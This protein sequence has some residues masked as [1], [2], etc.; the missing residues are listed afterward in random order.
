MQNAKLI[1]IVHLE[2]T[3]LV[4][5]ERLICRKNKFMFTY[6]STYIYVLSYQI[7]CNK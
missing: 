2:E 1:L 5:F 7:L 6:R 4:Y 3:L